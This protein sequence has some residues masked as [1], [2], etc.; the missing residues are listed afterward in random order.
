MGITTDIRNRLIAIERLMEYDSENLLAA[1]FIP[2]GVQPYQTPLFLNFPKT[3]TRVQIADTFYTIT[4]GW[5]LRLLVRKEGDGF[6]SENEAMAMDLIDLTYALFLP[7]PRL[8]IDG[9]GLTHVTEAKLTG[10]SGIPIN[11]YPVA[12]ADNMSYYTVLFTMNI[13]YR[14]ICT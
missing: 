3:A 9:V 4:R 12:S 7:R 14:S 11:P 8:E 6:R 1:E 10:D 2:E 13:T 5:E